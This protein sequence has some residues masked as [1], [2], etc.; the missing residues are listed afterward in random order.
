MS[1][2]ASRLL[3]VCQ[4]QEETQTKNR[5][6]PRYLRVCLSKSRSHLRQI[7]D[8]SSG[9][10]QVANR[11][12]ILTKI[13]RFLRIL[14]I[15]LAVPKASSAYRSNSV[16]SVPSGFLH[17]ITAQ[18]HLHETSLYILAGASQYHLNFV[19]MMFSISHPFRS[20][21]L[22]VRVYHASSKH[23]AIKYAE[24]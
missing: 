12:P 18:C 5:C 22:T 9:A 11:R 4:V 15:P 24:R 23:S 17:L 8:R 1:L 14:I 7:G 2:K 3:Y 20:I 6:E 10:C 21:A 19:D 13:W 16:L